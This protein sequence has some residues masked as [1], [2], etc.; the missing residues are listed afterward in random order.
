MLEALFGSVIE[1]ALS[2][3]PLI[4]LLVL[5]SPLLNKR[6][7]AKWRYWV[8][9][10]LAI[11]LAIPFNFSLP[12]APV[13]LDPP[14][15]MVLSTPPAASLVE[16]ESPV[17]PDHEDPMIPPVETT[18]A[19][20][21]APQGTGET[22]PF[23]WG[24][25]AARIWAAGGVAVLCW[26]LFG[27]LRFRRQIHR[28]SLPPKRPELRAALDHLTQELKIRQPVRLVI[29]PRVSSPMMTGIFRP[30]ILLP[31]EDYALWELS[32]I[33]KHELVHLRR[34]DILYKSLM[35]AACIVQWLNPLV[36]LMVWEAG[37][38]IEISCDDEVMAGADPQ[39][40]GRYGETILGA[41]RSGHHQSTTFSTY[42][43]G[44]ESVMKQR[45]LN[46]FDRTKK[47][48]GAVAFCGVLLAVC[49]AGGLVAC[50]VSSPQD[51]PD[52]SQPFIPQTPD[53][54][55]LL[56][57]DELKKP[58]NG[59]LALEYLP[60]DTAPGLK[61]TNYR[62]LPA[63][64]YCDNQ[65]IAIRD[66]EAMTLTAQ[67]VLYEDA[68]E[69][70]S[71]SL[72]VD[73]EKDLVM[74]SSYVSR[75]E[76]GLLHLDR[77]QLL[78]IAENLDA[79]ISSMP[80][81]SLDALWK[82]KGENL[83][84]KNLELQNFR[85]ELLTSR[86]EELIRAVAQ[87]VDSYKNGS[88]I[89]MPNHHDAYPENFPPVSQLPEVTSL[90]D[91]VLYRTAYS[92]IDENSYRVGDLVIYVP[93]DGT[94][95]LILHPD[96]F[97]SSDETDD[98]TLGF[99]H[100]G[101]YEGEPPF[102]FA[103]LRDTQ[104]R[105]GILTEPVIFT[106]QGDDLLDIG[107]AAFEAVS[108]RGTDPQL[109]AGYRMD[110][111]ALQSIA[112]LAGTQEEFCVSTTWDYV[113]GRYLIS[114]NG[115]NERVQTM[116]GV[117]RFTWTD[118]Y[119]EIRVK[120]LDRDRYQ[121][122]GVGTGGGAAGLMPAGGSVVEQNVDSSEDPSL[123]PILETVTLQYPVS[124]SGSALR[125]EIPE[126]KGF[127]SSFVDEITG[128]LLRS[129]VRLQNGI[130]LVDEEAGVDAYF[131]IGESSEEVTFNDGYLQV[132]S[133]ETWMRLHYANFSPLGRLAGGTP[134]QNKDILIFVDREKPEDLLFAWQHL[135][136]ENLW[137]VFRVPGYGDWLEAELRLFFTSEA[138]TG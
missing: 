133:Q 54:I 21:P 105:D 2:T 114:A 112:L 98:F 117:E 92:P 81:P 118:C 48:R 11:R 32:F 99:G 12:Q 136:D 27:F 66:N 132:D 57:P 90:A 93:I 137:S 40:R 31:R 76:G 96:L 38:D 91:F 19:P 87:R 129:V 68:P 70:A 134:A 121:V 71:L 102:D 107:R 89:P 1:V 25:A 52:S 49:L 101:F 9:L 127:I 79:L 28:W 8:W 120:H 42:F 104:I 128:M 95:W 110:S 43:Y 47:R 113:G 126:G 20:F 86:K 78:D 109:P 39:E 75:V 29:C 123:I 26:Q 97:G 135:E 88:F 119:Q 59:E 23:T 50:N 44:G 67:F 4:L 74:V 13:Q 30:V 64:S 35:L 69:P 18:P 62:G 106:A 73:L 83:Q 65:G 37:K 72:Q 63:L 55:D 138:A 24:Q 80:D 116:N 82:A 60:S 6:F 16:P 14:T 5:C 130:L 115:N 94:H 108:S 17:L 7:T 51:G 122:I 77:E 111:Y 15:Q 103:Y 53:G 85:E 3:A 36:Y 84:E 22:A 41:I 33:L 61:L 125:R 10:V 124:E 34:K 100:S 58:V 131:P 46:L 56:N 45:L